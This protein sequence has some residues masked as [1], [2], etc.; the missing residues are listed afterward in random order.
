MRSATR[1]AFRARSAPMRWARSWARVRRRVG[2]MTPRLPKGKRYS[3]GAV[4]NSPVGRHRAG[5]SR[6]QPRR[7]TYLCRLG[8]VQTT[9]PS[10]HCSSRH[11]AQKVF[12]RWW[13]R[14]VEVP[15][16]QAGHQSL[17]VPAPNAP[18]RAPLPRPGRWGSRPSSRTA[19][20]SSSSTIKVRR[21][22]QRAGSDERSTLLTA[23]SRYRG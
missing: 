16:N 14:F 1:S 3:S 7:V 18:D 20:R 10:S 15:S 13:H 21:T 9:V 23:T 19:S 17:V 12:K 8:E 5:S 22:L 2:I 4:R 6:R 11:P